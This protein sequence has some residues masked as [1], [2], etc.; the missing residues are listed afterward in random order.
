VNV[1]GPPLKLSAAP[2]TVRTAPPVLGQHTV[3]VLHE[4]GV[5]PE[6]I[7]ALR[8]ERVIS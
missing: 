4:L 7:G 8:R 1:L 3:S 2:A 6:D 5:D